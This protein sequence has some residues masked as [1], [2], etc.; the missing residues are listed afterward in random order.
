MSVDTRAFSC[1]IKQEFAALRFV[2]DSPRV[3]AMSSRVSWIEVNCILCDNV[4]VCDFFFADAAWLC[5][6][7]RNS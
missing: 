5:P 1:M 7:I 2:Y 4:M 3:F 6:F